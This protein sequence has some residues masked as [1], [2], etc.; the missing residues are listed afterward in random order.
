MACARQ[1]GSLIK[2]VK[3]LD[4]EIDI[5]TVLVLVGLASLAFGASGALVLKRIWINDSRA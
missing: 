5:S 2:M 3:L 4:F 1:A